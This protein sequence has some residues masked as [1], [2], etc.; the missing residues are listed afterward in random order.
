MCSVIVSNTAS[1]FTSQLMLYIIPGTINI[2][3]MNQG[4]FEQRAGQELKAV[5]QRLS[6]ET[7]G[8]LWST[9]DNFCTVR[10]VCIYT[11]DRCNNM[12]V[13]CECSCTYSVKS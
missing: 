10:N 8:K 12:V 11:H 9:I 3:D 4:R 6:I 2:S 1:N 13:L 7:T 5:L